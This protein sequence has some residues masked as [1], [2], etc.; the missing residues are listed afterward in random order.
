MK[1]SKRYRVLIFRVAPKDLEIALGILYAHGITT[2]EQK[3]NRNGLWLTARIPYEENH[4]ELMKKLLLFKTG[5]VTRK[6]FSFMKCQTIL[7]GK[8]ATEF[9][10]HLTPFAILTLENHPETAVLT[11]DPRGAPKKR[12]EDTLYIEP[13]LAFGTGTHPT[14]RL[15]AE[16]IAERLR[17]MKKAAV[18]DLGCGT[19]LLAMVA[20]KLG[21]SQ[22]WGI[23]NDPI[24]L[25]VAEKNFKVNGMKNMSLEESLRFTKRKFDL[26]AANILL[27]TLIQLKPEITAHLKKDGFLI[28]SGLLY[29]DCPSLLE[30]YPEFTLVERRNRKGWSALLL[31]RK[32]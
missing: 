20:K 6:I 16:F 24:A 17:E 7:E 29:E 32:K 4:R 18:A 28:T 15:T 10:K 1:K 9:K 8:W 22:V 27:K 25:E 19:G 21:A 30:A 11:V 23:D 31:K 2:T 14:T 5:D 12:R 3:R 13:G 26:I